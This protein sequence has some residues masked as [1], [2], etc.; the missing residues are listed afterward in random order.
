MLLALARSARSLAF[1]GGTRALALAVGASLLAACG[2]GDEGDASPRWIPLARGFEPRPLLPLMQRWQAADGLD[3]AACAPAN[4]LAVDVVHALDAAAWT[5]GPDAG[6]WRAPRPRGAFAFGA[7]FSLQLAA[8]G[9]DLVQALPGRELRPGTFRQESDHVLLC[10]PPDAPP[11]ADA[12]LRQQL[13]RGRS[14]S[15]G[16]WCLYSGTESGAGIPVWSGEREELLVDVPAASRFACSVRFVGAVE[17]GPVTVRVLLDGAE[18]HAFT[19]D[20]AQLAEPR[21]VAFELPPGPAPGARLALAVAG[22]PGQAQFL[23]PVVGP[24]AFGTYAARPWADARPDVVLFLADTFRA[25]SLALAGGPADLTPNLNRFAAGAL[26]FAEAR[27]NAAWTLPSIATLLSGLAPGQ[28]TA[29]ET[30]NALPGALDTLVEALARAGWRTG[31]I[32]DAAF[33]VP[34]YGLD[35]GFELFQQSLP[36][37]WDLDATVARA[38]AF[39]DDDDGRPVFLVVHTYRTHMPY[40]VGPD[41]SLAEWNALRA[42]GCAL[43]GSRGAAPSA[44]WRAKLAECRPRLEEL[45]RAGVRDLDRGFGAFL[46]GLEQRGLAGRAWTIFTSDHGEAL[47]ENDD[48]GHGGDLWDAK[49]RVPMLVA[50]PGVAPR[51]VA[52]P[53]TLLD[54]PATVAGIAGLEPDRTWHGVSLL[55]PD[56]AGRPAAL[57]FRLQERAHQVTLVDGHRK[58]SVRTPGGFARGEVEAA[59]ELAADPHEVHDLGAEPWAAALA[60]E[61]AATVD[62][63]LAPATAAE[64]A[65][66]TREKLRELDQLG[67]GGDDE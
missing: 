67:Y 31:A 20:S 28:H 42:A 27:A 2:G 5:A 23:R 41:E 30:E 6:T 11:P 58:L 34:M 18:V 15:D 61:H 13:W 35:Q 56:G 55:A 26:R 24:A 63:L 57:A 10:L 16:V 53:V 29:N 38:L 17:S 14:A 44:E 62:A 19:A 25:D 36:V 9:R 12:V 66:T 60:R 32:T 4:D 22:P 50:G 40:R 33:F 64:L 45:Y 1:A 51:T 7:P 3:P 48:L 39:L 65:P 59:F 37:E 8:G 54:L 46:A 49:L 43:Y 21:A 52:A 47:G